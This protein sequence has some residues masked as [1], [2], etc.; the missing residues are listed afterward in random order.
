MVRPEVASNLIESLSGL[1]RRARLVT[2]R[3]QHLGMLASPM[4]ALLSHIACADGHRQSLLAEELKVTQSA[5][6]RQVAH[7][8]ALGYVGRCP[9]PVDGR[10]FLLSLTESGTEALRIHRQALLEWALRSVTDWT[11]DEVIAITAGVDKLRDAIVVDP[12]PPH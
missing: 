2:T 7:A 9:D 8:E 6:S 4:G 1:V 3:G 10:A 12:V 11:E 5:L